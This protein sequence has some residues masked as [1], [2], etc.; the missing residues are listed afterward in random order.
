MFVGKIRGEMFILFL[1]IYYIVLSVI[2]P[3]DLQQYKLQYVNCNTTK[4]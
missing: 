1:T 2:S 4:N 3:N